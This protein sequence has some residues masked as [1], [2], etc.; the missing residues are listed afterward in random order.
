M[1]IGKPTTE[2]RAA[3]S[4]EVMAIIITI[5]VLALKAEALAPKRSYS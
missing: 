1:A 2:C 4:D 3:L 5:M